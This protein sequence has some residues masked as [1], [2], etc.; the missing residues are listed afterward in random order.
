MTLQGGQK[1]ILLDGAR[2]RIGELTIERMEDDLVFAAIYPGP[3]F[4]AVEPLFRSFEV[5]VEAQALKRVDELDAEIAALNLQLVSSD[6]RETVPVQDVQIWSD[7][8][9]TCRLP[10]LGRADGSGATQ[11]T[12]PPVPRDEQSETL[13]RH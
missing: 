8:G 2:R 13:A 10:R 9:I 1:W 5:A 12:I 6:G 3:D 4:G 11:P 7:G